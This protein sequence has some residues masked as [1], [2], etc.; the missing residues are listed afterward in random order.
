MKQKLGK[1]VSIES[2][3][4]TSLS[5]RIA[6]LERDATRAI[7][8]G[9]SPEQVSEMIQHAFGNIIRQGGFIVRPIGVGQSVTGNLI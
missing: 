5:S 4:G 8:R 7:E 2:V 9:E 6:R 1:L 3:S